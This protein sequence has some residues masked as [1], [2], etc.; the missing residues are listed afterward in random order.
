MF[1]A[2]E[3]VELIKRVTKDIPN[4]EVE[5]SSGLLADYAASKGSCVIIK[6]LRAVSDFEKEFQMAIVNK[7]LNP[8]L[9]TMF[10]SSDAEYMYLS[11]S[12]VRELASY[13]Q[14]LRGFVHEDIIPEIEEKIKVW[15]K[16]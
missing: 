2:E 3:R 16:K 11:S 4:D 8:E 6:G 5:N 7:K 1:N 13:E 9:D 14:D 15:R 12:V 10:L